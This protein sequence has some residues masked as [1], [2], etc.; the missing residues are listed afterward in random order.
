MDEDGPEDGN[1]RGLLT[2]ATIGMGAVALGSGLW[3]LASAMA[4]SADVTYLSPYSVDLKDIPAGGQKAIRF[5]RWPA[6]IRHRTPDQIA[7]AEAG[8][9]DR[10]FDPFARN[11]NLPRAAE[12]SDANRRATP[13]GR[14]IIVLGYCTKEGCVTLF[15]EGDFGGWFCPCCATHYDLA[16]RFRRGIA[17]ENMAIPHYSITRQMQ[18]ELI[19]KGQRAL[20]PDDLDRLIY[21]DRSRAG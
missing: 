21:G 1:R 14:F 19:P 20:S 7:L 2:A 5:G 10:H 13:D 8:D 16:G 4:P 18:V 6:F 17:P 3:G 9:I 11:A 12:A 15:D